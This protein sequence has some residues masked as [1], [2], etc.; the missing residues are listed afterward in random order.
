M[1][2][3]R[4]GKDFE[5]RVAKKIGKA[6]NTEPKRS[7]YHG[8]YWDDNG[9]DLMP[10]ETAPFLVQCKAVESG[11]F[12]HD[13]LAGMYQ[14][15]TKI[16]VVVHKL[17]RRPLLSCSVSTT[18]ASSWKF[19]RLTAYFKHETRQRNGLFNCGHCVAFRP[20]VA[21]LRR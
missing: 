19:A 17:N 1:D 15:K 10:D 6:L 18:F 2:S 4:K 8:K 7:S 9:V 5:L 20:F 16:N 13:T 21:R 3:R 11:K 14:D 12:L